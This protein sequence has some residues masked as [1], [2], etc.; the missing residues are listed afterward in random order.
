MEFLLHYAIVAALFVGIDAVWLK[1]SQ[2]FYAR[3][4]G[5]LMAKKPDL[6]PAAVFYF[7]YV[8]AVV[9]FALNPAVGQGSLPYAASHGALLGLVMFATYDLTNQAT[10]RKWPLKVTLVDITWG[11]L[12]TTLVTVLAFLVF[13]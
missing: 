13:N 12:S 3:H 2:P 4:L 9:I 1:S 7:L 11:T 6:R 8:F 10:L 5:D